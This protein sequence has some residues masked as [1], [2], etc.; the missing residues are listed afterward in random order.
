MWRQ[1][2]RFPWSLNACRYNTAS[3][4]SLHH[5]DEKKETMSIPRTEGRFWI[6]LSFTIGSIQLPLSSYSPSNIMPL[7]KLTGP[8]RLLLEPLLPWA[9]EALRAA[10][11]AEWWVQWWATQRQKGKEREELL[12]LCKKRFSAE[13]KKSSWTEELIH[14]S[15]KNEEIR[16]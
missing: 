3:R 12:P 9:G 5:S 15:T 10:P 8:G 14:L 13:W 6:L 16:K 2:P 7:N 1:H 11:G 4:I